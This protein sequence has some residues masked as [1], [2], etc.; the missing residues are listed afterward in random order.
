[1]M[2]E[3][4]AAHPGINRMKGLARSYVWWPW[5]DSDFENLVRKCTTCREHQHAPVAAPLHPWEFPDG[6]WKR[7]HVDY[8]GPFKVKCF[9][10]SSMA[11]SNGLKLP[12]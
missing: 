1:M 3:L 2:C 12:P 7:I 6:P 11:F 5:M 4:H 10:W 9:W 8:A